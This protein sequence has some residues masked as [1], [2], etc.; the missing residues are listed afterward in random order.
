MIVLSVMLHL[1]LTGIGN[2]TNKHK[3]ICENIYIFI[4]VVSIL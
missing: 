2:P 1:I 3:S 4:F